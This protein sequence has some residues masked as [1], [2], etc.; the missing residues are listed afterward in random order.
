MGNF[1][2]RAVCEQNLIWF[3]KKKRFWITHFTN[4]LSRND[5]LEWLSQTHLFFLHFYVNMS[6]SKLIEEHEKGFS[7]DSFFFPHGE[8]GEKGEV[9]LLKQIF[10]KLVPELN[11]DVNETSIL[12]PERLKITYSRLCGQGSKFAFCLISSV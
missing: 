7:K 11:G 12:S 8:K 2:F 4:I 6:T 5:A 10:F 1:I 3:Q 9:L